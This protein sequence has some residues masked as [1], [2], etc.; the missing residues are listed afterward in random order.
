MPEIVQLLASPVHRLAGRPADGPAPA[1]P[2]E[3]VGEIQ[4]RA[5]L[6][7]VGDRYFA[8]PAHRNASVTIIARESLPPGVDLVQV[9]RNILTAGLSVDD[10]IGA[11][12]T[13]D[14]GDGPV[15]LRVNRPANP[16]AWMD[17]TIGPGAFRALR[18]RGGVRCTPLDDGVLRLG[19]V[20][21]TVD[22]EA[23]GA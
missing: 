7:V 16:C 9:R 12:L 10:L 14:S 1:P 5:G 23:V 18:R 4:L 22:R 3:L 21:A 11:V 20:R 8:K 13:L 2:D 17:V 19:P 15:R 6:G